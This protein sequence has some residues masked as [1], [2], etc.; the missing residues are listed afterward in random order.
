MFF[1]GHICCDNRYGF[2]ITHERHEK[3]VKR[4]KTGKKDTSAALMPYVPG[5]PWLKDKQLCCEGYAVKQKGQVKNCARIRIRKGS[6]V[7]VEE[8][9]EKDIRKSL[10][11]VI[12]ET[13]HVEV[14]QKE[15]FLRPKVK[16]CLSR[17][18]SCV[19]IFAHQIKWL[20]LPVQLRNIIYLKI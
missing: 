14:V 17:E 2:F 5:T 6:G 18:F 11:P 1:F 20:P 7:R 12:F 8:L 19:K 13:R 10:S 4:T 9:Y 16:L 3:P 15:H